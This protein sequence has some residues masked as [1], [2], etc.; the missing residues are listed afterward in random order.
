[1]F[2]C[3]IRTSKAGYAAGAFWDRADCDVLKQAAA[4]QLK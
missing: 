3:R 1:M 2:F 4:E